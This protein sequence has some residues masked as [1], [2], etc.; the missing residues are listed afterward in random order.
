[1][2]WGLYS[3]TGNTLPPRT[4]SSGKTQEETIDEIIE[5]FDDN[6][7]V[8]LKGGVGSGKSIIGATVAGVLGKGI[9][10]VPV[11][12]LQEQYEKDYGGRLHI[13]INEKPLKIRVLKGRDN[14]TCKKILGGNVKCSSRV[15]PCTMPLDSSTPRWKV[16]RKCRY[17][18]PTY[19]HDVKPLRNEEGC[20][21][22][23]YEGVG[24]TQYMYQRHEGCSYYDQN[25]YYQDA[26][27]LVYN[28]AKWYVDSLMGRKPKVD[29]EIF[30]E[31]DLFLDGLTLRSVISER[32]I[33]MLLK[34][35]R[36][37]KDELYRKGEHAEGMEIESQAT[38]IKKGFEKLM[39]GNVPFEPHD[40]NDAAEHFL[41][42]L[43]GF[44]KLLET[45]YADS[46]SSTLEYV[47]TYKEVTS[48]YV[49]NGRIVFFVPE[50]SFV[51]RDMLEKSSGKILFM[52]A[53]L[54]DPAVLKNV[55]GFDDFAYVEGESRTPGRLY[56][57]RIEDEKQVN[58]KNWQLEMFREQYWKTL[59]KIVRRAE[60]PTLIQVHSYQYLP[61]NKGYT[62]VPTQEEIKGMNQEACIHSFKAGN[63]DV[64][65]STKTDRG[66]DLPG[67]M[68]RAVVIMKYPFP[69][70][71][72]PI[73]TV[74]KKRLGDQAF[75]SYYNDIA[76]RD[77]LQQIGR[78]L[79][80]NDDWVE[81][82]SPD[83]RVHQEL[84][85]MKM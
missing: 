13:K 73:F 27:I 51:M 2:V 61:Q 23:E 70:M 35:A 15:L 49:E 20:E 44:L 69:S 6:R 34:E 71:N 5:R 52:S 16:A 47:L 37:A 14:F 78:G 54:Q 84:R 76:R 48:F 75:W 7:I 77:F 58:W 59:S 80:S 3:S 26:D 31:A 30:D 42:E 40:L 12:P 64:L 43:L 22:F 38:D 39:G 82:W 55:Y 33:T 41:K 18:S 50:P 8:L 60:R 36:D 57:R 85:R 81:V 24:G 28:N 72:D 17:W 4:F 32:M 56:A 67:E 53:T 45:D 9:I 83:L 65:F 46:V 29:V 25:N 68:C 10:N 66:I 79:R 19:S 74:M 1:M 62:H 63:D 11:K 21:V